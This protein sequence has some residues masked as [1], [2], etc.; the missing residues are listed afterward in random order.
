MARVLV[1]AALVLLLGACVA[2]GPPIH[3]P[4][5]P[6]PPQPAGMTADRVVFTVEQPPDDADRDGYFDTYRVRV[7]LFDNDWL[8]AIEVSGTYSFRMTTAQGEPIA[9]WT[10]APEDG[11][12]IAGSFDPGPGRRFRL[13]IR[14]V[15]DDRK[16]YGEGLLSCSF[17]PTG[18]ER[19]D[20]L[21]Q[22]TVLVGP[23]R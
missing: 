5:R 17:T 16:P 11:E 9:E 10:S 21:S 12:R 18:G 8:V 4:P 7:F 6:L 23:T 19:V 13:N 20:S 3:R 1:P 22:V 15:T 14:D 2:D